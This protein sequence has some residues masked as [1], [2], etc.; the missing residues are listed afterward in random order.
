MSNWY[1]LSI[2]I[3]NKQEMISLGASGYFDYAIIRC[4]PIDKIEGKE[5]IPAASENENYEKGK[6]I[7]VPIEVSYNKSNDIYILWA[8]NHR[9]HQ[10]EVNGDKMIKAFV[11]CDING[12][13]S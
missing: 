5:P 10:A 8:G 2:K 4:V 7:I 1:K 11:S 13:V 12:E 6:K 9:V 3:F